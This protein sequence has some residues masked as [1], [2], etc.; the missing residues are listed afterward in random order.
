MLGERQARGPLVLVIGVSLLLCGV[1][2]E[3]GK[4]WSAPAEPQETPAEK[5]TEEPGEKR[6]ADDRIEN[7]IGMKLVYLPAG[8]FVIGSPQDESR[9]ADDEAQT[10]HQSFY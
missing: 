9:R 10:I 8:E 5:A 3:I 4:S 7:S 2:G 1:S 6:R